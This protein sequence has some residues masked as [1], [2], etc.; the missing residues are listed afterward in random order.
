MK[1]TG[2]FK[3]GICASLCLM[4]LFAMQGSLCFAQSEI[5]AA[6]AM[7]QEKID[8]ANN[9][10]ND[11][12]TKME[13]LTMSDTEFMAKPSDPNDSQKVNVEQQNYLYKRIADWAK[14][15]TF[16]VQG[17]M[18]N[19]DV[20]GGNEAENNAHNKG[21]DTMV[22]GWYRAVDQVLT[23]N[24]GSDVRV[25][26]SS[27]NHDIADLMGDTFDET[28]KD[29]G[30]W[31]YGDSD[32]SYVG[33]F[34]TE[35]NGFDFIT[36]DYN[37]KYNFGYTGQRSGYQDFL[38]QTLQS[39]TSQ[40]NYDATKPIFI[41]AHSGYAGTSLG[42]NF[43]SDYDTMGNDLQ[44]ILKDY[45]QVVMFSAHTHFPVEQE[46]SIYQNNFTFVENGSMNYMYLDTPSNFVEGGYFNS[47]TGNKD[48]TERTCN[49][50]SIL[51]DGSTLVRR[52]DVS[53]Q[54]WIG[55]PWI[56]DTTKGKDGFQYTNT[57]RSTIA[58]WFDESAIISTQEV[59]EDR[60]VLNFSQAFD[61]ELVNYYEIQI[62][63]AKT[64]QPVSV[65]VRQL[66]DKSNTVAK[67]FNGTFR[68]Y[69]KFYYRP[70]IMSFDLEGL[71]AGT[72]YRVVVNAVDD[73]ENRSS[74]ALSGEFKTAGVISLP[75]IDG[76]TQL[77]A[78]IQEGKYLEMTFDGDLHEGIS[79]TTTAKANGNITFADSFHNDGK[80][81]RVGNTGNDYIDL[82]KRTEWDLGVDKN[83]TINFWL[84]LTS[85]TGYAAIMGNKNWANYYR[86]GINIA[87][88]A[89]DTS[90]LE[91]TLGD[92]VNGVYC[93]G[94]VDNYKGSWHMMSF[95]IDR[96]TQKMRTYYDGVMVKEM[97]IKGI[98]DA[99]SNLNMMIGTDASKSYGKIG[100]DMDDLGM[101][102]RSLSSDDIHALYNV[103]TNY[104]DRMQ[105]ALSLG[106]ELQAEI[107]DNEA[108][109]Q[110]YEASVVTELNEAL[111]KAGEDG[112]KGT[113]SVYLR[114]K[115]AIETVQKQPVYYQVK[116]T[117]VNGDVTPQTTKVEK[118]SD[119]RF[120]L[121]PKTGYHIDQ[122]QIIVKGNQAFELVGNIVTIKNVSSAIDMSVIFVEDE[123][124]PEK[125]ED[126][127]MIA[128][129]LQS[130]DKTVQVEGMFYKTTTLKVEK[131]TTANVQ[132]L[133]NASGDVDN[134]KA[135]TGY[136]VRL[137]DQGEVVQ[138]SNDVSVRLTLD[139]AWNKEKLAVMQLDDD[140]TWRWL[141]TNVDGE[142]VV[143][144]TSRLSKFL[145]VEK[146]TTTSNP[147]D[148]KEP[149]T[150]NPTDEK[151]Q[152]DSDTN[153]NTDSVV[154][155]KT[156][157]NKDKVE[158]ADTGNLNILMIS[159]SISMAA[160]VMLYMRS[161]NKKQHTSK[162]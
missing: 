132:T 12:K 159:F 106:K 116:A 13:F 16:D 56:V 135:L 104:S 7:T 61:D 119:V 160:V 153:G 111:Q 139:N 98:G 58:P 17:I 91:F 152:V 57:N 83:I 144:K 138:P 3:R 85:N 34:H 141:E 113:L 158:T 94:N 107:T 19:G 50:V 128:R 79:N 67:T 146:E 110:V 114:L 115:N 35:I 63:N 133:L 77:P 145:L 5:K 29:D 156:E 89:S 149:S 157:T 72:T 147:S 73:F 2:K 10:Y 30:K 100:F 155:E 26:L 44:T 134:R 109:G 87:P 52:F 136:D 137:L 93:T 24:F 42:G 48:T 161:K 84:K 41:Q 33:N 130:V 60:V 43:H 82:G 71:E 11:V 99:T 118:G 28:H 97:D 103:S 102:N 105:K 76:P 122:N 38:K 150:S 65:K 15:K 81:V 62:M 95:T 112:N 86:K 92:E 55:M 31:F 32:T 90:K 4:Q 53:N 78:D 75:S 66:P 9:A 127:E 46:T 140:G 25:M 125:P 101:W 6:E 27:G 47:N 108:N 36:L 80:A 40:A 123:K 151:D 14:D 131:L 88:Q 129:V 45:P 124:K 68:A 148:E 96:E 49:F 59:K 121:T 51:E 37:G 142:T 70:N 54:R 8:Q 39:I 1:Y 143:F 126:N 154:N 162:V 64:N 117:A 74:V 21:D 20:V 18:V 22:E 69:S 120:T 23:Q